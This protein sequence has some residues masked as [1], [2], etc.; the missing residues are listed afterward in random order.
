M[1]QKLGREKKEEEENEFRVLGS[2]FPHSHL[3]K[4]SFL[5]QMLVMDTQEYGLI[6]EIIFG[7]NLC[8]VVPREASGGPGLIHL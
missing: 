1:C 3:T 5:L 6:A 8:G 7:N 2:S 4:Y